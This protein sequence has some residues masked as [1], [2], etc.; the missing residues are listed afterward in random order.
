[1]KK[2]LI[3]DDFSN[4]EKARFLIAICEFVIGQFFIF[5]FMFATMFYS[6]SEFW[7]TFLII[8]ILLFYH[9]AFLLVAIGRSVGKRSSDKSR[10]KIRHIEL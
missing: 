9:C 3:T 7:I 2:L 10:T 8:S 5:L 1:M 6:F 4:G